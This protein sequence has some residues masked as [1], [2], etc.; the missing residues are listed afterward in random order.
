MLKQLIP[1]FALFNFE[2]KDSDDKIMIQQKQFW[3]KRDKAIREAYEKSKF[4][5]QNDEYNKLLKMKRNT[6]KERLEYE[7]ALLELLDEQ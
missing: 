6:N 1:D 4:I 3:L 2:I 5:T 7:L